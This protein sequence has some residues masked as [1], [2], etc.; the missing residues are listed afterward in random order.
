MFGCYNCPPIPLCRLIPYVRVRGLCDDVS[1]SKITFSREGYV[2]EKGAFIVFI[3]TRDKMFSVV[4]EA[5]QR[6]WD[7]IWH[8][9]NKEFEAELL[10]KLELHELMDYGSHVL[11][12][13]RQPPYYGLDIFY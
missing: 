8:D 3:W 6:D 7:P 5:I 2:L 9:V 4:D 13:G 10:T 11:C 1:G 12:F